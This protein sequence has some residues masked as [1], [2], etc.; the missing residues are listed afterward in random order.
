MRK[1]KF[2]IGKQFNRLFKLWQQDHWYGL[3]VGEDGQ[4]QLIKPM[5][6]KMYTHKAG[7]YWHLPFRRSQKA[8]SRA[9]RCEP[10]KNWACIKLKSKT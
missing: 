2:A 4:I 9:W 6:F 1:H 10:P 3:S 5:Q 8:E 7:D